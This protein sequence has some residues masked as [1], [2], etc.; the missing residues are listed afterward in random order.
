MYEVKNRFKPSVSCFTHSKIQNT[1]WKNKSGGK[2][3]RARTG[4]LTT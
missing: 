2:T 4:A 1:F 3:H